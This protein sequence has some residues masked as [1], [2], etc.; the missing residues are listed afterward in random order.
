MHCLPPKPVPKDLDEFL[1]GA[2][3][4]FIYFSMGSMDILGHKNIRLFITHGGG[5]ST[6][7]ALYNGVP[8][9]VMPVFADQD[10]NARRAAEKGFA[11]P[12]EVTELTE[13]ILLSAINKILNNPSYSKTAKELS[14]CT[15]C[16]ETCSSKWF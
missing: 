4:G 3:E 7:E 11:V 16:S 15:T 1:S 12:L 5:L 8:L 2:K 10:N 13:E 9:V 14:T 6:Q